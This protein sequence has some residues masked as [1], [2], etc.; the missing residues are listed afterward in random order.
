[1]T[2]FINS[3]FQYCTLA[4]TFHTRKL[5]TSFKDLLGYENSVCSSVDLQ[6][7][8]MRMF[9]AKHGLNPPFMTEIF[10]SQTNEYNLRKI[11]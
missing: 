11:I 9:K 5:N 2:S 4:W 10:L 7:L 1:M 6:I 8:M 3:Q